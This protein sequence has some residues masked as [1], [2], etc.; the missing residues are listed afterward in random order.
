AFPVTEERLT[1]DLSGFSAPPIV[2]DITE[3][4]AI[5]ALGVQA[6]G[7]TYRVQ[8]ERGLQSQREFIA[9]V[10][11]SAIA[12]SAALARPVSAQN[13]HGVQ[14]Y[15]DL[16]IV[17][18]EPFV[19]HAEQLA[20]RRRAQGLEVLVTRFDQIINE[21]SGGVPDVRAIRDYF[22]FLYDRAPDDERR[23]QF[24]LL[25]GDGHYDI[26]GLNARFNENYEG[27]TNW[28]YPFE[29]SES[30][31][32]VS[33]YTSDDYF[34]LLDDDEGVWRWTGLSGRTFERVD[35]GVG[36]LPIQTVA[37][38]EAILRKIERYEDPE[39]FGA[40][41]ANYIFSADDAFTGLNGDTNEN[42]LHLRDANVVAELVKERFSAVNVEK[43]FATSYPRV[44]QNGFRIPGAKKA[45]LDALEEGALFFNYSGHGGPDGLAQ[46]E[47]FTVEDVR[48]LRNLDRLSVFVT[49]TCSFGWWDLDDHQSGAEELLLNPDGG[50]I[51]ALTTVRIAYTSGNS[52]SLNPGLNRAMSEALLTRDADGLPRRLG[53]AMLLAKNTDVGLQGNSRKFNLI[54]DPSMRLGLPSGGVTITD[55]GGVDVR[56][57]T[58]PVR[59]LDRLT[60]S[61]QMLRPDGTADAAFSGAVQVTM[62]DAERRVA[63]P[64]PDLLR[65]R[66]YYLVREDLIW[67]GEVTAQN[68][69]FEAT[70]VVPKDISYSNELG[71]ISAYAKAADRDAVGYTEN[72]RVGGTAATALDDAVG[73]EVQ[74][75]LNDTTFVSGSLTHDEPELIVQLFDESGINTVGAGVGHEILLIVNGDEE[76][77]IDIGNRYQSAENSFQR[78]TIRWPLGKQE[79]G[80]N[81]LTVRAWDVVN[82]STTAELTYT[83]TANEAIEIRNLL[84][85]P[86]P[87]PGPTRFVFEHN[88]RPGTLAEVEVR[89]YTL[90]GRVVRIMETDEALP[91]GALPGGLVQIPWDGLD[92]DLDPLGSGVYLYKVRVATDDD[93]GSRHVTE[94]LGKLAVIR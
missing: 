10:P 11:S 9:F 32:P 41:R 44:F 5:R 1:F 79:A 80:V 72:I 61:G 75:F 16:V 33:S 24:G 29:T 45:I 71:R 20:E 87:T 69:T 28:I 27:L 70:F 6:Q 73:P 36:R 40:W 47:V 23:L 39:T 82:N 46:E 89:V 54:G 92:N 90:A 43:I 19:A 35:I 52:N 58:A 26:R 21:F 63:I 81:A 8:A 14:S 17:A 74:L 84:N 85:Y 31:D 78:G 55:V 51:A 48:Q 66:P 91:L 60:I 25:F 57:E 94:H 64:D 34:G 2:L 93:D 59:A 12:T 62:W 83:V 18:P 3:P 42:D 56:N 37:D 30:F 50:G 88:Q 4:H 13:L 22:K 65:S 49:A 38:A 7:S 77:A 53:T 67:S 76:G 86:N 68:G 15:P